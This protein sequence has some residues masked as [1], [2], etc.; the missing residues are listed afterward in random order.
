[1]YSMTKQELIDWLVIQQTLSYSVVQSLVQRRQR[2]LKVGGTSL[3]SRLSACL[4]E[5]NWWRLILA[6]WK[7]LEAERMEGNQY[8]SAISKSKR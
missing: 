8:W 4:T 7:R 2:E 3:V 5:A 1:M 6:E